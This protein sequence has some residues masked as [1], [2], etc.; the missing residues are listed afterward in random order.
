MSGMI[1]SIEE[2]NEVLE[3]RVT[4]LEESCETLRRMGRHGDGE[5]RKA[6]ARVVELEA[7]LDEYSD[8]G[9]WK[10][11]VD[12]LKGLSNW[13]IE[14]QAQWDCVCDCEQGHDGSCPVSLKQGVQYVLDGNVMLKTRVAELETELKELKSDRNDC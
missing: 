7:K 6:E 4:E 10:E 11:V 3:A 2:E 1:L 14:D 9:S 12:Q 5:L 8:E 13:A